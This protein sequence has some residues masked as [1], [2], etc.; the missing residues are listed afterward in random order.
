MRPT[1]ERNR[2]LADHVLPHEAWIRRVVA[3]LAGAA[4]LDVDDVIQETYAT[5]VRLRTAEA[6]EDPRSYGLRV[7]KSICLR[8]IRR[9]KIV[10]IEK[11]ANLDALEAAADAPSPEQH[12]LGRSELLRVKDAIEAMP[13]PVRRAF[14]LRRV[15][16]LSQ[17]EVA[18]ALGLSENTVEKQISR[19]IRLL[20]AQFARGGKAS[21]QASTEVTSPDKV[22]E[23]PPPHGPTRVRGEHQ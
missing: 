16:G 21:R 13:E 8:Q 10:S 5:L 9:A 23:G 4:D 12:A 17:R 3:R 18:A 20:V 7:A 15:E 2:W 11:V 1:P 19:G 14:W 22:E 6:I